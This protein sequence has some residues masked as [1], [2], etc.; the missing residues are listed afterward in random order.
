ME[1]LSKKEKGLID[2][3]STVVIAGE[4]GT[5]LINGNGEKTI[6]LNLKN[7]KYALVGVG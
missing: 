4:V 7:E 2:M 6:K 5:M 3:D 1:A